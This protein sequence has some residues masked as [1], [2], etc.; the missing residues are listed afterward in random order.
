MTLLNRC[1]FQG[2]AFFFAFAV[3]GVGCSKGPKL[4][5]A[6]GK[7]TMNGQPAE[8]ASVVFSPAS[9][10]DEKTPQPSGIV[11]ADGT[12]KLQTYPHGEGA[13]PGEYKVV[14]TWL[15]ADARKQEN[16]VN[17]ARQ[18]WINR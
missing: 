9:G 2:L 14:I 12:Y 1:A 13:L 15:P 10:V 4:Y 16:P 17:K 5:P 3:F 6:E 7:V 18:I 11:G 8:G